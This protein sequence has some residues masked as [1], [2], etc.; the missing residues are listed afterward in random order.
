MRKTGL[1]TA[2]IADPE[3][4]RSRRPT[5]R[6]ARPAAHAALS[7]L[8]LPIPAEAL[9]ERAPV[10][11]ARGAAL[12]AAAGGFAFALSCWRS[13]YLLS[14]PP[15][16]TPLRCPLTLWVDQLADRR[17]DRRLT[18][19]SFARR[20]VAAIGTAAYFVPF[21]GG[22][23]VVLSRCLR[24]P[25]DSIEA[26]LATMRGDGHADSSCCASGSSTPAC[27]LPCAAAASTRARACREPAS[28]RLRDARRA[29]GGMAAWL[30]LFRLRRRNSSSGR[31]TS[32]AGRQCGCWSA[33]RWARPSWV[34]V[35]LAGS[36]SAG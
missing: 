29:S 17:R 6:R 26:V 10:C 8:S 35:P 9:F 19:P 32:P 31:P 21:V 4:A 15:A 18:A 25:Q 36:R 20:A 11:A 30:A 33:P 14:E 16:R 2:P 34:G 23:L 27:R 28:A 13:R 24:P 5:R 7:A 3:C 12:N 1:A 22:T